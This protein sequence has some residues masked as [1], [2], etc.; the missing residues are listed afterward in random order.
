MNNV[1]KCI[2]C[3]REFEISEALKHEIG[4]KVKQDVIKEVSE[5]QNLE[6]ADLKKEIS[7]QK[8]KNEEFRQ[9]ELELRK[10]ARELEEKEKDIELTTARKIDEEKK[11]IAEKVVR[12][13]EERYRLKFKEQEIEK[14]SL[15]RKIEELN[16]KV[17]QG[18]SQQ[19]QG[20]APEL[21]LEQVLRENFP[22]DEIIPVAKGAQGADIKQIVKSTKGTVCGVILWESKHTKAWKDEWIVTLKNNLRAEKANVAIIVSNILPKEIKTGFESKDGVHICTPAYVIPAT[23]LIRQ[24]LI[25]VAYQKF[26]S[27]NRGKDEKESLYDYATSHVFLQQLEAIIEVHNEQI[28]QIAKE[29]G[30]FERI[31]KARETQAK[32]MMLSAANIY[33]NMQGIIGK[34]MPQIK[35]LDLAELP[36]GEDQEE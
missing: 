25:E 6:L 23:K 19:L 17:T 8:A 18:G 32:K 31:W 30:A 26:V 33:G 12:D 29:R 9:Q 21:E 11:K 4:E 7:E 22:N 5:K 13:E 36:S 16:R 35:S 15:K 14:E 10:K 2:H 28:Q 1:I 24:K 27:E 34:E 3:G 20:E